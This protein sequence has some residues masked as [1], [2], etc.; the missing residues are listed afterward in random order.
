MARPNSFSA[1]KAREAMWR[2]LTLKHRPSTSYGRVAC[3]H[4]IRFQAQNS[5][6]REA[7][8]HSPIGRRHFGRSATSSTCCRTWH[9]H[10]TRATTLTAGL[11]CTGTIVLAG[12]KSYY[13]AYV[14]ARVKGAKSFTLRERFYSTA[15]RGRHQRVPLRWRLEHSR[16]SACSTADRYRRY[17]SSGPG[18]QSPSGTGLANYSNHGF[19][20]AGT[21]P[22]PH[23]LANFSS[24]LRAS[25][26]TI[27]VVHRRQQM[28][29]M[30]PARLLRA[31]LAVAAQWAGSSTVS[32]GREQSSVRLASQ[33]AFD[34]FLKPRI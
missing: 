14:E 25:S 33:G 17:F 30:L 15:I 31:G 22:G 11:G 5:R 13:E 24:R 8:A 6:T 23:L 32:T 19:Y 34:Q 7:L 9:S 2:A 20:S 4:R 12:H 10:S 18:S 1:S 27:E 3:R 21:L 29:G 28:L 16:I 26:R